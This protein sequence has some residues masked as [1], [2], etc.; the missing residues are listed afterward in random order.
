MPAK[1]FPLTIIAGNKARARI[2]NEGFKSSLFGAMVGAS[3][4]AKMLGLTHLD[5]YL[6]S[7]FLQQAQQPMEL[8]GSSIGSWRHAALVADD[9][10]AALTQLQERY[11]HQMWQDDDPRPRAEVVD[12][13]CHWVIDGFCTKELLQSLCQHPRFT[14]HIVTARGRGVNS[15]QNKFLLGIGMGS[16]ALANIFSRTAVAVGFQRVVFSSGEAEAFAFS[17][18]TTTHVSMTPGI[19]KQ[20]LLA[21]GSIPFLMSG[22]RDI[23]GAPTGH[24]WDGGIIDYH[25]DFANQTGDSLILYP[26]FSDRVVQGW[27]DKKLPWRINSPEALARTV[28]IAPSDSYLARLPSRKFP[29][30][31]DFTRL[32]HQQRIRDWRKAMDMSIELA[33][34]L[35]KVS[36]SPDPLSYLS[37]NH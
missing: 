15:T 13:L 37:A 2:E 9:P 11:L 33:D 27:F 28:V 31:N 4:G 12:D 23:E 1:D 19:V 29:D 34:A 32:P 6:F 14:T 16:V 3:G 20:A 17:D 18:F 21:S 22:Q 26:H 7:D 5:R 36:E 10:L 35:K 25:F 8:Y 24:Y 30:R